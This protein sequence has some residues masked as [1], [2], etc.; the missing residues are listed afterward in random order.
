[1]CAV[2]GPGDVKPNKEIIG[3]ASVD[4]V[5]RSRVGNAG[6]V[7]R[8]LEIFIEK[9]CSS[10]ILAVLHPRTAITVNLQELHD[11]GGLVSNCVNSTCLALLDACVPMR[12]LVACVHLIILQDGSVVLD[13][14]TKQAS[15]S[16]A[17]LIFTFESRTRAVISSQTEGK[18]SQLKMQECLSMAKIAADKVFQFYRLVIGRKFC[19]E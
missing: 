15:K 3:K 19:K 13:P 9:S 18:V 11:S 12:F 17:S 2:Y 6:V 4:V 1:M 16:V 7:D 10:A 14:N 5:Y 8:K